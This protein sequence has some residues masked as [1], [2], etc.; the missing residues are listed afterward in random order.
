M[1]ASIELESGTLR[2]QQEF[3]GQK[4]NSE[5]KIPDNYIPEGSMSLMFRE[6]AKRKTHAKFK[7]IFDSLPPVGS[8]PRFGVLDVRYLHP[9]KNGPTGAVLEVKHVIL[10]TEST[11][12]VL[13]DSTGNVVSETTEK[14]VTV[15]VSEKDF[16]EAYPYDARHL[17]GMSLSESEQ[18]KPKAKP[19]AAPKTDADKTPE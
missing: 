3:P 18:P 11:Y 15:P 1:G 19:V 2:V 13:L 5:S 6:V 16:N 17:M 14:T 8:R 10:S 9:L 4:L 7:M 12:R